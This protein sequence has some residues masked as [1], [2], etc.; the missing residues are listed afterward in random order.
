MR[1]DYLES[2]KKLICTKGATKDR[3]KVLFTVRLPS[4]P[5]LTK[6]FVY[7]MCPALGRP[8][9]LDSFRPLSLSE[10]Q[11]FVGGLIEILTLPSGIKVICNEEAALHSPPLAPNRHLPALR[12]NVICT[13]E[14]L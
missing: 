2:S 1:L 6:C 13:R 3:S 4:T 7:E 10:M 9:T 11:A 12:G 14:A 8:H 5:T